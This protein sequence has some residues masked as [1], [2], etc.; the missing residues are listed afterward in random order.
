MDLEELRPAPVDAGLDAAP[1]G[2]LR[3]TAAAAIDALV[4]IA[5]LFAWSYVLVAL[6]GYSVDRDAPGGADLPYFAVSIPFTWLYCACMEGGAHAATLG[7]RLLG[8]GVRDRH[9]ERPGFGR[10]SLRW[11]ARGLTLATLMVGWLLILVTKRRQALHDLAAGTTVVV[12]R[13]GR[14]S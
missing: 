13:A 6:F 1:A 14:R 11:L 3:R 7:K 12:V 2:F 5:F 10:A 4:V 8:L 9:G